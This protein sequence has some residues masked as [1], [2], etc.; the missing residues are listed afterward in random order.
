MA[1]SLLAAPIFKLGLHFD[2]SYT[3]VKF[4]D[5]ILHGCN[6]LASS[7]HRQTDLYKNLAKYSFISI[8]TTIGVSR[9]TF[10]HYETHAAIWT[11][12]LCRCNLILVRGCIILNRMATCIKHSAAT[13]HLQLP[14]ARHTCISFIYGSA[15]VETI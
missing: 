10:C 4:C 9:T 15:L 12:P 14:S 8:P 11:V 5:C 13:Q 3:H 2:V 1:P 7:V 6:V